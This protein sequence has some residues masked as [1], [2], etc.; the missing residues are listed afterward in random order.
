V[1]D[2]A[3]LPD[4]ATGG[5]EP[6]DVSPIGIVVF[7]A[8]LVVTG[9]VILFVVWVLFGY[10]RRVDAERYPPRYPLAP[11]GMLRLPPA[12]RLQVQPREDLKALRRAQEQTLH[13]YGWADQDREIARIPI[14]DAMERVLRQGLPA[15]IGTPEVP[16][17]RPT[18]A[19]SGRV[20]D[21][22]RQ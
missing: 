11:T 9:I 14:E 1:A 22:G 5:H 18:V 3:H 4:Q 13:G 16:A 21:P 8:S 15:R 6:T 10:F 7:A 20:I 12:P 2:Q 17:G 19:S